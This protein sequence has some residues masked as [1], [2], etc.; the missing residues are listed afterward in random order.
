MRNR[1]TFGAVAVIGI[2]LETGFIWTGIY[3]PVPQVFFAQITMHRLGSLAAFGHG[4][5]AGLVEDQPV[6]QGA[7]DAFRLRFRDVLGVGCQNI[8]AARA[9]R[10]RGA[11]DRGI[12]VGAGGM[13]QRV[14]RLAGGEAHVVHYCCNGGS[15]GYVLFCSHLIPPIRWRGR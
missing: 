2:D 15:R 5:D 14:R 9:D 3:P 8:V 11:V 10:R 7:A 6:E 1:R 12:L 4:F 13:R